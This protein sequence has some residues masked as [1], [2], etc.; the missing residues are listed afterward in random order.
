LLPLTR[1][2]QGLVALLIVNLLLNPG[3]PLTGWQSLV[4]PGVAWETFGLL[5]LLPWLP[6]SAQWLI[7]ALLPGLTMLRLADIVTPQLF[8]RAFIAPL[9]VIFVPQLLD[10]TLVG[11]GAATQ[12]L[13]LVVVILAV[14][15]LVWFVAHL[16]MLL[17]RLSCTRVGLIILPLALGLIWLPPH[18]LDRDDPWLTF[19]SGA[20][21]AEA[22]R[23][24][25]DTSHQ[26]QEDVRQ[27]LA[28]RP[29]LPIGLPNLAGRDVLLI[30]IESYGMV[31]R[32]APVL[33]DRIDPVRRHLEAELTAAGYH[34]ASLALSAP[35]TG[36]GSWLAHAT[37]LAGIPIDSQGGHDALVLASP[38]TLPGLLGGQER[39]SHAV[40][41]QMRG[42][43]PEGQRLGFDAVHTGN[44][45]R[46]AG[47]RFSWGSQPD[48]YTLDWVA[49][50]LL[51][52]GPRSPVFAMIVLASSHAPF[53]RI[54]PVLTP[55]AAGDDGRGYAQIAGTNYPLV[56]GN[57]RGQATGFAAAIEYS[58]TA[59]GDFLH[60]QFPDHGLV[61]L[62][63]DHQ[64]PLDLVGGPQDKRVIVHILSR[65]AGLI[66]PWLA[67]GAVSGL[68]LPA[69]ADHGPQ[70]DLLAR[71]VRSYGHL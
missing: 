37:T 14:V 57:I 5:A 56:A 32:T 27:A 55:A 4:A 71:L 69:Q 47:P 53:D 70:A 28:Q 60:H 62:L 34:S 49:R 13:L 41:P 25:L 24:S 54:P 1:I 33:A 18:L 63:G 8:G 9:D 61:I 15:G 30:F 23:A 45:F 10:L 22:I 58:L 67:Q 12:L 52:A 68:Q 29:P 6:R 2:L 11:T 44:D 39:R 7:A 36:G 21:L 64:P 26:A 42:P 65:D 16:L 3:N 51:P 31:T 17:A 59:I 35:I 38:I 48:R 50:T 46:Y 66:T 19:G 40:Q 20:S 43:W